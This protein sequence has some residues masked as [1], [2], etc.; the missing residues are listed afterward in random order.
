MDSIDSVFL[1]K[2]LI[3]GRSKI[4][5][6]WWLVL[7]IHSFSYPFTQSQ[8]FTDNLLCV[9]FGTVPGTGCYRNAKFLHPGATENSAT[10]LLWGVVPCTGE[11]LPASLV[12]THWMPEA[13]LVV[14]TKNVFRYCW[15]F[16]G[17]QNCPPVKDH[18]SNE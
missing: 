5:A 11:C 10:F 18:S 8:T 13:P 2:V 14:T 7:S 15:I 4:L 17:R 16:S 6:W 3:Q 9:M 12:S 1:S